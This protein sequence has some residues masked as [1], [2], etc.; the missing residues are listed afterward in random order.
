MVAN[1]NVFLIFI[2]LLLLYNA[3]LVST[4]QQSESVMHTHI[5]TL[6]KNSIPVWSLQSIEQ[7]SVCY[8]YQMSIS[9]FLSDIYMC[10]AA[11]SCLTL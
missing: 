9:K 11:Q 8:A 10:L 1:A 7:S 5:A 3:V 4:V 2:G 6:F